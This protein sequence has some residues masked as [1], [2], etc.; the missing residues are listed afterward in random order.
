MLGVSTALDTLAAQANG[1][2]DV[3]SL[4]RWGACAAIV[5]SALCVPGIALLCW[6][7]PVVRYI[8]GQPPAMAGMTWQYCASLALGLPG[9]ALFTVVQKYQQSQGRV[10]PS[11]YV[12]LA[13]NVLNIGTNYVFVWALGWGFRGSPLGTSLVRTVG[14]VC[15]AGWEVVQDPKRR[16][17]GAGG[18][19]GGAGSG[20]GVWAGSGRGGCGGEGDGT[21]GKRGS[22]A[23]PGGG[24]GCWAGGAALTPPA[25]TCPPTVCPRRP[26]PDR[27]LPERLFPGRL[28]TDRLFQEH[29][30]SERL[31]PNWLGPSLVSFCALGLPGGLM[32]GVEAW[33]F[34]LQTILA[35]RMSKV[36]APAPWHGRGRCPCSNEQSEA[37]VPHCL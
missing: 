5:L 10:S 3:V 28:L 33:A 37:P 18:G 4:R 30:F 15:L 9:L 32:L 8:F 34:D 21:Y 16:K 13:A 31:L 11:I 24:N 14:C 12:L 6:S 35:G 20:V 19:G 2:G 17:G 36:R 1:A 7:E 23:S 26:F 27:L 25:A 22:D 29:L